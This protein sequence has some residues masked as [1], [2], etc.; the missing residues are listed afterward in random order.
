MKMNTKCNSCGYDHNAPNAVYCEDCGAKIAQVTAPPPP[1]SDVVKPQPPIPV[2]GYALAVKGNFIEAREP[3]RV[4]GRSDFTNFVA[5]DDLQYIS[6]KHFTLTTENDKFFIQDGGED[7]NSLNKWKP[8]ASGT[9]LNT[10]DI[11]G[12]GKQEIKDQDKITLA[13]TVEVQFNKKK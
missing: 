3:L 8:S 11:K 7:L 5:A 6:R 2:V 4:F 1:P 9:K 12:L 10:M 13:D